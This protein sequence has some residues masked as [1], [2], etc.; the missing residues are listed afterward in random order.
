[1]EDILHRIIT[2]ANIY[3]LGYIL[4]K[5]KP[6]DDTFKTYVEKWIAY[7]LTRSD[8]MFTR[9]LGKFLY[10]SSDVYTK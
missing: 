7:H 3:I 1:M 5:Y 10:S 2:L 6:A 9:L 8:M 4:Y